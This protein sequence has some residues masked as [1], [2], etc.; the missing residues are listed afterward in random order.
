MIFHSELTDNIDFF[1]H[2][3]VIFNCWRRSI[4]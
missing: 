4:C 3:L 2:E 1:I